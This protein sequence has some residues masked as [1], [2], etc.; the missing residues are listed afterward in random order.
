MTINIINNMVK[1]KNEYIN[2]KDCKGKILVFYNING[3]I[4]I[5][6]CIKIDQIVLNLE[7]NTDCLK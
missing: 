2:F 5:T 6:D 3:E 4:L 1:N 7:K